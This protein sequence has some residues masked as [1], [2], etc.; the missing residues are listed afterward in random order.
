MNN[1]EFLQQQTKSLESEVM[2][3][4]RNMGFLPTSKEIEAL[5]DLKF[6]AELT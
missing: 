2:K 6:L 1:D 4:N 3:I 5:P